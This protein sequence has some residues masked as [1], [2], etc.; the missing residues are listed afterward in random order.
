MPEVLT[1]TLAILGLGTILYALWRRWISP[2]VTAFQMV[3]SL[4]PEERQ[5]VPRSTAD[6]PVALLSLPIEPDDITTNELIYS[7]VELGSMSE[8]M[9]AIYPAY[10]QWHGTLVRKFRDR[11]L[12]IA[13]DVEG[14]ISVVAAVPADVPEDRATKLLITL[15]GGKRHGPPYSLIIR[16]GTDFV[17]VSS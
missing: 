7:S 8:A 11:V 17:P 13:Q 1:Y 9:K 10:M 3:Y 16:P 5:W 12:L 2:H 14:K 6:L 4:T 15:I